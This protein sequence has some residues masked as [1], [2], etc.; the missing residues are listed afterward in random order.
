M[1][2]KIATISIFIVLITIGS[3]KAQKIF[4]NF[5]SLMRY[6]LDKSVLLKTGAIKISQAKKARLAAIYGIADPTGNLSLSYTN[7]TRLPV[8]LFPAEIFG[9]PPG[10]FKEV[11][12]GVQYVS[13]GNLYAD[14]KLLNLQGWENFKLSKINI[15]LSESENTMSLKT[16]YENI[17]VVYFNI[18]VLQEQIKATTENLKAADTLYKITVNKYN[19]GIAKQQDVNDAKANKINIEENINQIW[20]ETTQQYLALKLLAD[21]PEDEN[22][23]INHPIVKENIPIAVSVK[24]SLIG[25]S[26]AIVKERY[27]KSNYKQSSYSLLP[28]VSIFASQTTQQFN[29]RAKL[30][31]NSVNWIPSTYVGVRLLVPIPSASAISQKA[32]AKN[33]YLLAQY[34]TV[35][36]KI[37]TVLDAKALEVTYKKAI[38]QATVNKEIFLLRKDSYEKN[39]L[40]YN[41]GLTGIDKIIDSFNAM[42][43]SNYNLISSLVNILLAEAKININN[44]IN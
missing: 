40:N 3:A 33:D 7:N 15:L 24:P 42:V 41:E 17:A 32:K 27:A 23:S 6:A 4:T 12:T 16:L 14:V 43:N 31:D 29:T 39:F 28:T 44:K 19:A 1:N 20:F 8:N 5:D 35:Q 9:G 22:F 10:S 2:V 25:L 13:Y 34:N 18:V 36:V 26:N 37:K 38:S 30:F 11:R 21:I